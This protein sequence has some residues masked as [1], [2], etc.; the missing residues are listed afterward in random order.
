MGGDGHPAER[1]DAGQPVQRYAVTLWDLLT[2][3]SWAGAMAGAVSVARLAGRSWPG[4]E[5]VVLW[6]AVLG[7]ACVVVARTAGHRWTLA[8]VRRGEIWGAFA[9]LALVGWTVISSLIAFLSSRLLLRL[10]A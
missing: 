8:A 2:L 3:Q 9:Y 1:I 7:V 10:F 6:G 4:F 5:L